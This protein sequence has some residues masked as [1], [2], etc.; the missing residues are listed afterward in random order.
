MNKKKKI[1]IIVRYGSTRSTGEICTRF[2]DETISGILYAPIFYCS[3]MLTVLL[4]EIECRLQCLQTNIRRRSGI[5]QKLKIDY[6]TITSVCWIY[7]AF[8]F[9]INP[10]PKSSKFKTPTSFFPYVFSPHPR[11]FQK[12]MFSVFRSVP[13]LSPQKWVS[14]SP[15]MYAISFF[16]TISF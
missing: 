16:L 11:P 3:E 6:Q 7:S 5:I 9:T 10:S 4:D 1:I 15:C 12:Y 2:I 8:N 14:A 13:A